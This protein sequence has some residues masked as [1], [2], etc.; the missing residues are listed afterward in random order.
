LKNV[1]R[2]CKHYFEGRVVGGD[3]DSVF[4][5]FRFVKKPKHV[6]K[7]IEMPSN[8]ELPPGPDNPMLKLPFIKHVLRFINTRVPSP[9]SLEFE[10][11]YLEANLQAKKRGDY[12]T[13]EA[14]FDPDTKKMVF[15]MEPLLKIFS[16]GT[17]VRRRS[18]APY[19]KKILKGFDK[20]MLG[21][22]TKSIPERKANATKFVRDSIKKI[23]DGDF[24]YSDMVMTSYYGKSDDQY[25]NRNH[26]TLVI[27][28]KRQQRGEEPY[29]LGERVPRVVVV[30]PDPKAKFYERVEDP[31]Y[32]MKNG[33]PL[34]LSY[35]IEKQLRVPLCRKIATIDPSMATDM[36][37]DVDAWTRKLKPG[38]ALFAYMSKKCELCGT[39]CNAKIC[40]DCSRTKTSSDVE[41]HYQGKIETLQ[42]VI[43]K[44]NNVCYDCLGMADRT[45]DI[46]CV[47][48][49][50]KDLA[51]RVIPT[52]QLSD[53][54][55]TKEEISKMLWY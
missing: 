40:S 53:L 7:E 46:A 29:Q 22:H 9:M 44:Q 38:Q 16:K 2:S 10:K 52:A 45:G 25:S 36:F 21:D 20:L 26:P 18:T 31:L 54:Y 14:K 1:K 11:L 8:P 55:K 33:I 13:K 50:C 12:A 35:Y 41:R 51:K 6:F 49:Y 23:L 27:N 32:A 30:H 15:K 28:R 19:A 3:T 24:E 4:V 42:T 43:T 37:A 48:I 47:N 17:E 34:D 39:L 5:I